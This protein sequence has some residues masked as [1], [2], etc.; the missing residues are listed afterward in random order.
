MGASQ[1][2]IESL[3]D[4]VVRAAPR[5]REA[6]VARMSV[7]GLVDVELSAAPP[8]KA[9]TEDETRETDARMHKV[10]QERAERE[11]TEQRRIALASAGGF[12]R[13]G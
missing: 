10:E 8:G 1:S 11:A 5:L 13:R 7:V 9:P 3:V 12:R 6:G 4:I 2:E